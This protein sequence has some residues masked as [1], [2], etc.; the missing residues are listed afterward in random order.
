[1]FLFFYNL[2]LNLISPFLIFAIICRIFL[3]K[4]N[5]L[6]YKEKFGI[7]NAKKVKNIKMIWFHA[8][9]VGE[10]KSI[11]NLTKEF[12]ERNY[13]IL[14]TTNTLLS[15]NF[16]K[17]NFSKKIRHQF[18]PLDFS[19]TTKKFLN[20]W[21]PDIGIFIE[22]EIWPNLINNCKKRNIPLVLLQARF[23][24]A[25]LEKWIFCKSFFKD[26]LSYFCLIIAQSQKEKK[27][28]NK[29]ADIKVDNIYNLKNSS[30]LLQV[31]KKEVIRMKKETKDTFIITALSTHLGE[32]KIILESIN[33]IIKK[34]KNIILIIQ[35]RHPNRAEQIIKLVQS[36]GLTIKQRSLKEYP[37]IG[38][39]VYLAD[40]FG[41]SGTIISFSDL[42]ILGGTLMP[43]GGHNIIEPA[44]MSKCILVG[45]YYSKIYDTIEIFKKNNAIK[46]IK[47]NS[48]L[49]KLISNFYTDRNE[50]K[51]IGQKALLITKKFPR[52]EKNIV[53][54][55]IS[56]EKNEN[57]KILVQK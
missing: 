33:K 2:V 47:K 39:T 37:K 34:I 28:L 5:K 43:I 9:S 7:S 45:K 50:L 19:F 35:P 13:S 56:L 52:E 46:L 10:V 55:I 36:Y 44:Q 20:Y 53:N 17:R 4:E 24:S 21:K 48:D 41:E 3:G 54:Q 32:E 12:L 23:S 38:T 27:K 49:S 31:K 29:F 42:I 18:L 51:K 14:I 1:M 8:C 25:S 40:T 22:S 6:R 57:S 30:P 16:V 15:A 26:L 11:S